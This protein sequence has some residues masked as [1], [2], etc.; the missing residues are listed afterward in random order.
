MYTDE[1][2]L[3]AVAQGQQEAF[4]KLYQRF[5]TQV[6]NTALSYLQQTEDAEE[7]TQDVFVNIH[8]SASNFQ[9]NSTVR[10]WI[11]R[12]A[13]NKCMDKLRQKSAQNR[14]RLF[15][16]QP[17]INEPPEFRHPGI[18]LENKEAASRLFHHIYS[19]PETQKTAVILSY[20]E[21]LPRQEVADIMG[22]SR[23]AVESLL[24]R[25]KK[26]LRE[27]LDAEDS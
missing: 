8:R 27:K 12:I 2:L 21:D 24:Q 3:Q 9:G 4:A 23:K 22:T 20:V 11:Y 6:Y 25:A 16:L 26:S 18:L 14:F 19:L 10:T 17:E 7:V 5:A 1:E 13:I 15:P